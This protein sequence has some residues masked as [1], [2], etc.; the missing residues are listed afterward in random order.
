MCFEY[1]IKMVLMMIIVMHECVIIMMVIKIVV[2]FIILLMMPYC[3][4]DDF[5]DYSA[6]GFYQIQFQILTK[7]LYFRFV[8]FS[9]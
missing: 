9:S 7:S 6:F 2:D 3:R 5:N 8:V 4:T 1:K